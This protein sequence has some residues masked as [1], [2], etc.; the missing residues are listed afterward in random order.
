MSKI[1]DTIDKPRGWYNIIDLSDHHGRALWMIVFNWYEPGDTFGFPRQR[2][3]RN[4]CPLRLMR[5]LYAHGRCVLRRVREMPTNN[6]AA[7]AARED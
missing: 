5:W 6:T 7:S 3:M 2:C 1:G 4:P